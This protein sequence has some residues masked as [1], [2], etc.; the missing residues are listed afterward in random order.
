MFMRRHV[1][2]LFPLLFLLPLTLAVASSA[3]QDDACSAFLEQALHDL[4][5]NCD[6]LD[7]NSACYGYNKLGAT[8][9]E[10]EP[11]DYFSKVSDRTPL[12]IVDTLNSS[13]LDTTHNIWGVAVMKV[14][15]NVPNSLPGQAVTFV[16]LGDT[17]V[18]NDVSPTEAFTPADPV[19]VTTIGNVNI[20]SAPSTKAN[21][22]GSVT[23]GTALQADGRSQD[24]QWL[25]VLFQEVPAWVNV[26][27]VKAP[28]E[29]N[30]LPTITEA[31]RTPMQAFYVTTGVGSSS[32]H[33]APDVLM[34]QGPNTMRVNL[35]INGA[36]VQIGSTIVIRS[37]SS[38][39]GDL[40]NDEE[41]VNQFG[42]L[43][44]GHDAPSGLKCNITQIIVLDGQANI[45]EGG[46]KLPTGFTARSINCGGADRT[47]GFMTPWGGSR[48]L[49]PQELNDLLL[50]NDLPPNILN[51]PIH[52]PT[53]QEVQAILNA[54]SGGNGGAAV[55]GAAGNGRM[56]STLKPTSPLGTMPGHEVQFYWNPAAG[57]TSYTVRVYDSS[58]TLVGEYSVN[59]PTTTVTG[60]PSGKD[61][62]SWEVAA[63]V[64]GQ[65][66]C[67]SAR[68]NVLRDTV[69]DVAVP[70]GSQKYTR[71]CINTFT[72]QM[73]NSPCYLGATCGIP[74]KDYWCYC[75]A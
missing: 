15:A 11:D 74:L 7:R 46:L 23:D 61:N 38:T 20:R 54:L 53:P 63:Y 32:C 1:W 17:Q 57:A 22:V 58:Y 75:P 16:L 45:N 30:S 55:V 48:P 43:L 35:T 29:V 14:Q 60:N 24:G 59:A 6:A 34:I 12:N 39:Y 68:A 71:T 3:L 65:L 64:N 49:M 10:A 19:D 27:L 73:C 56:C 8:F 33:Q 31:L 5:Q 70:Q 44:T 26:S 67:T 42:G 2:K 51:Y 9:T 66:A 4:G 40:L 36:D 25:R 52:V 18:R 21:V 50:L 13:P 62:M 37:L 47:S 41:L 69:Y 72:G 28:D